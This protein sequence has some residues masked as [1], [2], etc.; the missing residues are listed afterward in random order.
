MSCPR[1]WW[2]R[3]SSHIRR[4]CHFADAL[5][6]SLLKHLLQID[7]GVSRM[8]VSTTAKVLAIILGDLTD[9]DDMDGRKAKGIGPP[10]EGLDFLSAASPAFFFLGVHAPRSRCCLARRRGLPAKSNHSTMK[11]RTACAGGMWWIGGMF[12]F[13]PMDEVQDITSQ[14]GG[15]LE[16]KVA[17]K[18]DSLA[19]DQKVLDAGG[20]PYVVSIAVSET[21]IL[22]TS[23]P[24]S[25]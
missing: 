19:A 13:K 6:P 5:S 22:L 20:N 23:P 15:F 14:L 18:A 9:G 1:T 11:L 10:R 17:A 8:T 4:D 3:C 21:V 25:D 24:H 16:E 7:G 2:S 12:Q